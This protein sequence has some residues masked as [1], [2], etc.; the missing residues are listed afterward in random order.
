MLNMKN[1]L[2]ISLFGFV[3]MICLFTGC[4][5]SKK[6]DITQTIYV[7]QPSLNLYFGDKLQLTVSPL[8]DSYQWSSED[9]KIA[10]VNTNGEVEA[11][12]VGE[13]NIVVAK[14][15]VEKAVPVKVTVPMIDRVTARPGRNRVQLELSIS[16]DRIKNVKII[17]LDNNESMDVNIDY[18]TGV[19]IAYYSGLTEKKYDF[20]L[21]S[22]DK[23]GNQSDSLLISSA[24][25]GTQYESQMTN[26]GIKVA[27]AFGNGACI[28]LA[29]HDGNWCE[30]FYTDIKGVQQVQKALRSDPAAYLIGYDYNSGGIQYRSAYMPEI[31]AIDTFYTTKAT[32]TNFNNKVPVFTVSNPCEIQIRDFDIGGEGVGYHDSDNTNSAGNYGY[33]QNL[34]DYNSPGVDIEGGLNIGYTNAGEWLMF[35][36][37]VDD[38]GDYFADAYLSVNKGGGS[39]YSFEVDG[40]K[41]AIYHIDDNSNWGDY[42]W[43]HERNPSQPQPKITLSKGFHKIKFYFEDGGFNI[44]SLKFYQ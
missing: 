16:L 28:G 17:R 8:N 13:T 9:E 2:M 38:A 39:M 14:G 31:T 4:L 10:K 42:R 40:V 23:F 22:Y 19:F 6:Y 7:N 3:M 21:F 34:G 30:F 41:T 25:Y 15:D 37:K 35:T 27:T 20:K 43:Y 1:F 44:M 36:V 24:A 11:T 12:G 26:R 18:K 5:E 33:R 32:Y 29:D